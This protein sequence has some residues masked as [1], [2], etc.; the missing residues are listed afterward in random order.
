MKGEIVRSMEYNSTISPFLGRWQNLTE[1]QK[2]TNNI[3]KI[4]IEI[5]KKI[6]IH[7]QYMYMNYKDG[8]KKYNL[9]FSPFLSREPERKEEEKGF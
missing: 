2:H 5:E 4:I 3:H 1:F 6:C 7:K 9:V 8:K